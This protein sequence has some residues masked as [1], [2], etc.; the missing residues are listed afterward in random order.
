MPIGSFAVE[1]L[2][3]APIA[4][5]YDET[6]AAMFEPEVIEPTVSFL[7]SLA[8]GGSALEFAVGTGRIAIPL[9]AAGIKVSGIELSQAMVDEMRRKPGSAEIPVV[10]GDMS[11]A[12][13]NGEFQLVYLVFNTISNLTTQRQQVA[14]FCNAAQHLSSG[15]YFVIEDCVPRVHKLG[16]GQTILPFEVTPEHIGFDEY[17]LLNQT[18]ISHHY[19]FDDD[20]ARTFQS[21]HRYAWPQEY[22]LMAYVAGLELHERWSDWNR[23]PFS[24]ES[25]KHISVWRKP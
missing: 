10:V 18:L 16:N 25:T 22:D 17:D 6:S 7:S 21:K 1:N 20:N 23:D 13:V 2:F 15:G 4:R 12:K 3:D 8:G 19:W 11:S 9:R 24:A 14:C 5:T